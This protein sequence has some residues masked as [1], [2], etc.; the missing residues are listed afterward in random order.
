[1][2]TYMLQC[3][4]AEV[5]SKALDYMQF[6]H[7]IVLSNNCDRRYVFNMDQMPV[8][9]LMNAKHTL[10]LIRKQMVHICTSSDD[11]ERV[12]IVVT[13]AADGMVLPSMLI[14]QGQPSGHIARM[15]FATYPATHHY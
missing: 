2:G 7:Q 9:F 5:E 6:M 13:I 8:Y 14:F 10:E 11:M 3:P 4:L 1:M 12:T 15:E